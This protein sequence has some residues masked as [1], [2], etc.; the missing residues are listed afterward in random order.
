MNNIKTVA[1]FK[2]AMVPGTT[3][4]C[5]HRYIGEH[6]SE[7][8]SL[9]RRECVLANSVD[10][11]FESANSPGEIS[12]CQWPKRANMTTEDGG[13]VVILTTPG[14]CELRYREVV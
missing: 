11:G 14:F 5:T 1:D 6:P 13:N 12:H 3:W 10:F 8:K 4:E 2:R 7:P 9:G